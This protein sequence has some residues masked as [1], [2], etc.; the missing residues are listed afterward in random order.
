MNSSPSF[1]Q[2]QWVVQI[3]EVLSQD[4]EV[5]S[6]DGE[7]PI[8]IFTVSKSLMVNKPENYIPQ[9]VAIGPYH[10]WRC[11]VY[12]MERHKFLAA[13]RAQKH[14]RDVT[15]EVVVAQFM[16]LD[17]KIRAC[18]D[19]YLDLTSETLAW[20]LAVDASFLLEFL[21]MY[22]LKRTDGLSVN[23]SMT[24]Q[25]SSFSEKSMTRY[26]ILRDIIKLENQIPLF[27]LKELFDF[28]KH[29]SPGEILSMML[30]GTCR[31]LAH[32]RRGGDFTLSKDEL[33][34]RDHLLG[35]LYYICVPKIEEI[36]IQ[37]ET[38]KEDHG[39][40]R[41]LSIGISLFRH[42]LWV[43]K[44][45][46]TIL[47]FPLHMIGKIRKISSSK[48]TMS[49]FISSGNKLGTEVELEASHKPSENPLIEETMIPSVTE[50]SKA[51][52]RFCATRGDLGSIKFDKLLAI[53]YLPKIT[54]DENSEAVL[55]N[56]VAYEVDAASGPL[57]FTRYTE[58]MNGIIDTDEDVK[59]LREN[60][61]IYNHLKSDGEVA[62]M[63]NGM[64]RSVKSTKVAQLD[65]LIEDVNMFYNTRWRVRIMKLVKKY[66]FRSWPLL[67]FL[68]ANLFLV[69]TSLQVICSFYDCSDIKMKIGPMTNS[70]IT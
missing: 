48:N 13:K 29:E 31:S 36:N 22:N 20:M 21:Q 38:K 58:F 49:S 40:F 27:L 66:V 6:N 11:E 37:E 70:T 50:L 46:W 5:K 61:I 3:Q 2:H 30:M 67:T 10:Q 25:V 1:N 43:L 35:L 8:S 16:K 19:R 4:N 63:W 33:L 9:K 62:D 45:L 7:I 60:K 52:V 68:A 51:G 15:F 14:L 44:M 28:Y 39:Y 34:E 23:T 24:S 12:D 32:F 18:Y 64:S 56:L 42:L 69:L 41:R 65:K 57:V 59:L 55:R 47:R 26:A 53:L 17:L 54:V